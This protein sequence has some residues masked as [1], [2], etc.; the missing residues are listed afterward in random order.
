[1]IDFSKENDEKAPHFSGKL[2]DRFF[3]GKNTENDEGRDECWMRGIRSLVN[4]R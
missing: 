3:Q 2:G 4:Q 1:V